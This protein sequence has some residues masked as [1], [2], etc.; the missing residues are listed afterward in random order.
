[1]TA[2]AQWSTDPNLNSAISTAAD[3]Q[4]FPT[5]VS[6]GAG[7]A[8]I[9]WYDFRNTDF[10]IYA[11]RINSSGAVQWTANGVAISTATNDQV[12]P[13]IVSDGAGGAIITWHDSRS[14]TN[15]DIYAQRINGSGGV[16]WTANG[17]A[18]SIAG[19]HQVGPTIVSD[20]AGG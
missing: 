7:G 11:Q 13:T 14:G 8:I 19:N 18:I 5:I 2:F 15:A 1:M 4:F 17:V 12:Y 6:D 3:N 20:G 10:D 9:T 16:Q